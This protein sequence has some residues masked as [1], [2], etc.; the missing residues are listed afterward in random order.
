MTWLSPFHSRR[1]LLPKWAFTAACQ[2]KWK[3]KVKTIRKANNEYYHSPERKSICITHLPKDRPLDTDVLCG[4]F[5]TGL[6]DSKKLSSSR[7]RVF[8]LG[9]V[10][11]LLSDIPYWY[12]ILWTESNHETTKEHNPN[13]KWNTS[14]H[15]VLKLVC[16]F[17]RVK[18]G[19]KKATLL[20][21]LKTV[22]FC[23][24]WIV[25]SLKE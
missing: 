20:K 2:W 25:S 6:W 15:I 12:I 7:C 5:L 23:I 19:N 18:D 22:Y 16:Q 14:M 8:S 1:Q 24:W 17:E 4:S 13:K 9:N 10:A 3:T 21:I 11:L